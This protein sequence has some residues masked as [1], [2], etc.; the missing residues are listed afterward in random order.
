VGT[1]LNDNAGKNDRDATEKNLSAS[2]Q[3]DTADKGLND[4]ADGDNNG[5]K[6]TKRGNGRK[7]RGASDNIEEE[8]ANVAP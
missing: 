5:H 8:G 2:D 1:D 4:S 7:N 3:G 6:M